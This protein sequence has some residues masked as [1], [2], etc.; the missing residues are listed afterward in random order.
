MGTRE[1]AIKVAS[2]KIESARWAALTAYGDQVGTLMGQPQT[3]ERDAAFAAISARGIEAHD[4]AAAQYASDID[5]I[6]GEFG[7]NPDY[8]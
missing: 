4:Q 3:P 8:T 1:E 5:S 2:D 7:V 6:Q